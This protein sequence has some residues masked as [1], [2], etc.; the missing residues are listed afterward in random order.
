[1]EWPKKPKSRVIFLDVDGVLNSNAAET[2]AANY[3]AVG[4][5]LWLERTGF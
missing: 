4:G 5:G 3:I 1:M 2:V